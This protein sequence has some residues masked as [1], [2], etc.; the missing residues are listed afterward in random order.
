MKYL[1]ISLFL[2]ANGFT[3]FAQQ[4]DYNT[5][6]GYVAK[7]YDVVSYFNGSAQKGIKKYV[8]TYDNVKF[9]FSS[10]ENLDTFLKNPMHYI[11]QY[12]GYCAYAIAQKGEKVSINP[13][14]FEIRDDKLYLFYN[15]WGV[16]TLKS[17]RKEG[18]KGLQKNADK[19]WKDI[20][21][22]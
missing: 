5:K 3:I 19:I 1:L 12:G 9:K 16:N 6:S 21:F 10:Q 17:W 11:P 4:V 13:K 2:L 22:L 20:K 15:S 14:T 8:T 18:V 7:G